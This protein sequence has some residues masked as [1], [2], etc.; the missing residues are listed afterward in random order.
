MKSFPP[1]LLLPLMLL[2][3]WLTLL[4]VIDPEPIKPPGEPAKEAEIDPG[5]DPR[6]LKMPTLRQAGENGTAR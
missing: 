6:P 2:V 1:L 3:L 4:G 5:L